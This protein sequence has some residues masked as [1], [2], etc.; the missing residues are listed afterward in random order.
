MYAPVFKF[1]VQLHELIKHKIMLGVLNTVSL[2][3][4]T[5]VEL[6]GCVL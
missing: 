1:S 5:Y 4:S 3:L 2:M 6:F